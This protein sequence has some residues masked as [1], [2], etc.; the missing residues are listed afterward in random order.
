MREALSLMREALSLMREALSLMREA[1]SLMR[2]A[3][4]LMREALS[5]MREDEGGTRA[6]NAWR[7]GKRFSDVHRESA[8]SI[9][10][11]PSPSRIS[12]VH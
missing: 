1:L 6:S 3:L 10:N 8:T 9:E 11:Q 7:Q 5:L 12:Q 2:E 4:S